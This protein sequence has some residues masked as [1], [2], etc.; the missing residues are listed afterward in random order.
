MWHV[1]DIS[2][3]TTSVTLPEM[4]KAIADP[5]AGKIIPIIGGALYVGAAMSTSYIRQGVKLRIANT[6]SV[7][8]AEASTRLNR[9]AAESIAHPKNLEAALFHQ[10]DLAVPEQAAD[11]ISATTQ[12]FVTIDILHKSAS[13]VAM[14]TVV[15][16]RPEAIYEIF[17]IQE[18][19]TAEA[20][21]DA[22][23][24][25]SPLHLASW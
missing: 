9:V 21:S 4:I 12:A 16:V 8:A 18:F 19:Q 11:A 25:E 2:H 5:F 14:G 17:V 6:C 13:A 20:L 22:D 1:L 10:C 23:T 3:L 7:D 24:D 15:V